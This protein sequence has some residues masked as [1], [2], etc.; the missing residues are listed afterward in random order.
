MTEADPAVD[1]DQPDRFR[2]LEQGMGDPEPPGGT[3]QEQRIPGRLSRRHQQEPLSVIG[4]RFQACHETL[5][6][7]ALERQRS[8]QPE[9][10]RELRG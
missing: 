10:S 8:R 7:P 4:Q 1:L 2:R 6:D 3:P 9:A 5:L